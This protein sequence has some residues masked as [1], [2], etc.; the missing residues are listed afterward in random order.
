MATSL[1]AFFIKEAEEIS[2]EEFDFN[3]WLQAVDNGYQGTF[4]EY[5]DL[6]DEEGN[7]I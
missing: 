6:F 5:Q 3:C 7:L 4:Q 2:E 1:Y